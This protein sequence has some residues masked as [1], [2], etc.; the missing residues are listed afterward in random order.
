MLEKT[1]W[2]LNRHTVKQKYFDFYLTN[3]MKYFIIISYFQQVKKIG[4]FRLVVWLLVRQEFLRY[5]AGSSIDLSSK[6]RT[7]A[8]CKTLLGK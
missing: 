6:L 1:W 5:D 4:F 7:S 2:F 8:L 3:F